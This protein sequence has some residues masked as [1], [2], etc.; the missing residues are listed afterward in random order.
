[1]TY[2]PPPVIRKAFLARKMI[3]MRIRLSL[4]DLMLYQDNFEI[5]VATAVLF[6]KK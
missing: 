2:N 6:G 1:M 3:I 4:L 5:S